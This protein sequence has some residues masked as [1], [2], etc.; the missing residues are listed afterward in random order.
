MLSLM[1]GIV[2]QVVVSLFSRHARMPHEFWLKKNHDTLEYSHGPWSHAPFYQ[3][4]M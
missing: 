2:T 3:T 1:V 4:H